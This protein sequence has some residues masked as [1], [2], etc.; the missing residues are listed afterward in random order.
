MITDQDI[1]VYQ[2]MSLSRNLNVSGYD[3]MIA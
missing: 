1:Q 2:N 3:A